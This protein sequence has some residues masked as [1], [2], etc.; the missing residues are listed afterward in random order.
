MDSSECTYTDA[1]MSA[2][3][4]IH[5]AV[6]NFH[7]FFLMHRVKYHRSTFGIK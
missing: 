4:T 2:I 5:K 7:L 1:L 6:N 3:V